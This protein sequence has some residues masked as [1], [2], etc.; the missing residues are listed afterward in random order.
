[1][2]KG[3]ITSQVQPD[4]P[5]EIRQ[6]LHS[7][8][9]AFENLDLIV[10]AFNP[11]TG[12]TREEVIRDLIHPGLQRREEFLEAFQAAALDFLDPGAN[13]LRA[14]FFRVFRFEDLVELLAQFMSLLEQ[15]RAFKKQVELVKL[16]I[17]QVFRISAP[18]PENALEGLVE[19]RLKRVLEN[20]HLAFA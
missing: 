13:S 14:R 12:K 5:E 1:M 7:I 18:D 4:A 17:R 3:L 15:R 20:P 19:F 9:S 10:Q 11:T 16:F 2:G 6:V 8:A